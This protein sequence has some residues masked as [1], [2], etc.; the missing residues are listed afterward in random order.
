[1]VVAAR[2][3]GMEILKS[4]AAGIPGGGE[5][6]HVLKSTD[7]SDGRFPPPHSF[8]RSFVR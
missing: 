2:C 1:M 3:V 7:A 6:V 4:E 5:D 8:V